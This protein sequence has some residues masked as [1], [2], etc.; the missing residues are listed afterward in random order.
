MKRSSIDFFSKGLDRGIIPIALAPTLFC[1]APSTKWP[2]RRIPETYTTPL[3]ALRSNNNGPSIPVRAIRT[4]HRHPCA[5][6]SHDTYTLNFERG[7]LKSALIYQPRHR[8]EHHRHS[9]SYREDYRDSTLHPQPFAP[10][11]SDQQWPNEL[12]TPRPPLPLPPQRQIP[13]MRRIRACR[14]EAS[15]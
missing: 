8:H 5:N 6:S 2:R 7:D 4:S 11:H 1:I 15:S 13:M 14:R 10:L 12:P 3:I 9:T